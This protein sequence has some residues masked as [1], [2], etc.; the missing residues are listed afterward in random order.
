MVSDKQKE[1]A[2]LFLIESSDILGKSF[3]DLSFQNQK[4]FIGCGYCDAINMPQLKICRKCEN[5]LK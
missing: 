4:L 5:N 3:K 2:M 1:K